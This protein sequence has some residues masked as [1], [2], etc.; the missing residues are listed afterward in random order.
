MN[1]LN[2]LLYKLNKYETLLKNDTNVNNLEMYQKKILSYTKKID[3]M[4]Q[5]QVGGLSKESRIL[6]E[7]FTTE[8]NP[9]ILKD[10]VRI[11]KEE[12]DKINEQIAAIN[13]KC[14]SAIRTGIA[15]KK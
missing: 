12:R 8:I 11:F 6:L 1:E 2:D 14:T 9:I 7:K 15:A 13:L 4:Q 10:F 3:N 5:M